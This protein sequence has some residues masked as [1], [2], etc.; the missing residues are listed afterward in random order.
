M[1]YEANNLP[2]FFLR[3]INMTNSQLFIQAHK[4]TK[5]IIKKGDNYNVTFGLCLKAIKAKNEQKK[6]QQKIDNFFFCSINIMF[7]FSVL[8]SLIL[9]SGIPAICGTV[10]SIIFLAIYS[11]NYYDY[12]N[13]FKSKCSKVKKSFTSDNIVEYI[14]GAMLVIPLV[15]M[16]VYFLAIIIAYS[17]TY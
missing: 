12:Y 10:L 17:P 3:C 11:T 13:N 5:Q 16:F 14:A 1:L 2:L 4:M 15:F 9:A 6:T 8:L 7:I